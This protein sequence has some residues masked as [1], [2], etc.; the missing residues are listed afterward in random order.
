[1]LTPLTLA[2]LAVLAANP[3][4]GALALIT[5]VLALLGALA[6]L[7]LVRPSGWFLW[8]GVALGIALLVLPWQV[9]K[10]EVMHLRGER[11]DVVITATHSSKK[12][13]GGLSWTCGIRRADG[14]PLPHA[15]LAAPDCWGQAV[16]TTETV[17]VDPDGWVPPV[18]T[19]RDYSGLGVGVIGVGG[20][21]ALWVLL[22]LAAGRRA[23]RLGPN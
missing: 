3:D 8:P 4:Y 5:A 18:S 15:R 9:F 2:G 11:T 20:T 7:M 22:A 17:V 16:G 1:M 12:K 23:L 21:A 13:S 10:S 19:D 6:A 14:Q